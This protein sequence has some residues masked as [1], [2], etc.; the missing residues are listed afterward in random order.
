MSK[1]IPNLESVDYQEIEQMLSFIK[2]SMQQINEVSGDEKDFAQ[3]GDIFSKYLK[4]RLK[5]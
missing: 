5:K 1:F 3:V 4:L 2:E